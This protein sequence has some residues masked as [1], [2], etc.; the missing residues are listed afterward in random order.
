LEERV[1]GSVALDGC[2]DCGGLWF[3]AQELNKLTREDGVSLTAVEQAFTR[4]VSADGDYGSRQCPKCEKMLR[5]YSFPHTPDVQVD[6]CDHCKGVWL[7]DGELQK[8]NERMCS[9]GAR[10]ATT[11]LGQED[12]RLHARAIT[13]FLLSAVCP[14]CKSANPSGTPKCY[15][16]HAEIKTRSLLRLCPRCD[17]PLEEISLGS[18]TAMLDVCYPCGG[19]WFQE[20]ELT[21]CLTMDPDQISQ[22]QQ[23]VMTGRAT[24]NDPSA[25]YRGQAAHCPGCRQ[26]MEIRSFSGNSALPVDICPVCKSVWVDAK[27]LTG[28]YRQ[29]QMGVSASTSNDA[30]GAVHD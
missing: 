22:L 27:E 16:C 28:I 19:V 18:A 3:D 4:T 29:L 15:S 2:K 24:I 9:A 26:T 1:F 11:K 10:T 5:A 23:R 20:G 25:F 6:I 21:I 13:G 14:S 7:D 17:R 8:I 12:P 30:W